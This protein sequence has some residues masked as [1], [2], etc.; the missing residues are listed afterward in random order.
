[1]RSL[2][3]AALA[4]VASISSASAQESRVFGDWVVGCDNLRR[5]SAVGLAPMDGEHLAF[6]SVVR[7]G[8]ARAVPRLTVAL[9][10]ETLY[11]GT[12]L[13]LAFDDAL[14]ERLRAAA[15]EQLNGFLRAEI[16]GEPLTVALEGVRRADRLGVTGDAGGPGETAATV[17][18][19]GAAAAL[20]FMDDRQR[21]AGTVTA[22]IARGREPADSVPAVPV[23]PTVAAEPMRELPD[24]GQSLPRS[25]AG[26][27]TADSGCADGADPIAARLSAS[28]M[29][30]GVCE[31]AGAYNLSYALFLVADGEASPVV[32]EVPDPERGNRLIDQ[33]NILVNPYIVEDGL[34][35]SSFARG[36]GLGD[37]GIIADWAWDGSGF[38]L[39]GYTVMEE[40]RGVPVD[41]WPVLYRAGRR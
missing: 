2:A 26:I 37:C 29:L 41:D 39:L 14:E 24:P 8:S 31:S 22:L 21:R 17:S 5:C 7:D 33:G 27:G 34:V 10:S 9:Y 12:P 4:I 13:T 23:M 6:V 3:A 35:L 30:W 28:V 19:V 16:A 11:P 18:L 32:L 25:L 38:R 40:C 15:N 20:R 36:R 1:M